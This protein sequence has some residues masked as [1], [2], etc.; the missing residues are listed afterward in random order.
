MQALKRALDTSR[1][2]DSP[3]QAVSQ[4]P[5]A[6]PAAPAAAPATKAAQD[7]EEAK[8]Q[9]E[10]AEVAAQAA[11]LTNAESADQQPWNNL[12][13]AVQAGEE[14]KVRD[15]WINLPFAMLKLHQKLNAQSSRSLNMSGLE[16]L[17]CTRY[18]SAF[19]IS[20]LASHL[21]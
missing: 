16:A 1:P 9:E 14:I 18:L 4:A 8:T 6:K 19:S 5:A 20:A 3:R 21:A 17:G 15:E 10:G 11:Q 12:V 2:S 7:E 13:S